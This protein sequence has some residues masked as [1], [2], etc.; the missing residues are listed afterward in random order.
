LHQAERTGIHAEKNYASFAIAE[1]AQILLMRR[2]RVIEW[3]VD[4][5]DRRF[6]FQTINL[7][8]KLARN[9]DELLAGACHSLPVKVLNVFHRRNS[10]SACACSRTTQPF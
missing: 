7:G 2:P 4:M 5:G 8:R 6:E 3:I 9:C 10:R 1:F